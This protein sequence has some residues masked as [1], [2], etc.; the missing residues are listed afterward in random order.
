M[1]QF[2]YVVTEQLD[3]GKIV[4]V[5]ESN[6]GTMLKK[7][8]ICHELEEESLFYV[9]KAECMQCSRARNAKLRAKKNAMP[10]EPKP[11]IVKDG[12]KLCKSCNE[13]VEFSLYSPISSGSG[14]LQSRCKACIN[15]AYR[16]GYAEQKKANKEKR[17]K[18]KLENHWKFNA[19]N[20]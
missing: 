10:K 2:V 8:T 12:K 13:W 19:A 15:K 9:G 17:A 5:L 18:G 11:V 14:G 4:S 6:R 7:C 3:P 1:T 20:N 16:D